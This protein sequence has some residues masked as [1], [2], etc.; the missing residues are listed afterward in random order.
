[1]SPTDRTVR[2][3]VVDDDTLLREVPR[4]TSLVRRIRRH[5]A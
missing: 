5:G 3:L 1:M 4:W 2:V